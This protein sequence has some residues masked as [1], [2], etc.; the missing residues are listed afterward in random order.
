[1]LLFVLFLPVA[2]TLIHIS[3]I[4]I[5]IVLVFSGYDVF[6]VVFDDLPLYIY[7]DVRLQELT[8]RSRT[9]LDGHVNRPIYGYQIN[10]GYRGQIEDT[11]EV[12]YESPGINILT[13][14]HLN[15]IKT[16]EERL[17]NE[18][19]FQK[20]FCLLDHNNY[21]IKPQSLIRLFDGTYSHVDSVFN[22][23]NFSNINEV[24][25]KASV[26]NE[27][28]DYLQ[29]FLGKDSV[30][31]GT[32]SYTT[33]TRSFFFMGWPL[34]ILR[35]GKWG[36][37]DDLTDY[38]ADTF[39]PAIENIR[40]FYL[41]DSFDVYYLS[42]VLYEHDLLEQALVDIKLAIGSVLFI[43]VFMC[44]QT[45]T[46]V[47][48]FLGVLSIISSYL[49]TNLFY[50]YVFQFKYFGFFHVIAI[51]LILGI[52]ADDL[53]VFYDTWRLT[54]RTKYPSDA[55]RLS[56]CYRKAAKTTFV[57]SLTTT[58]AFLVSGLSPLLP[59][60][61][62][63]IFT[64]C[65]VAVNYLWVIIY[66]PSIIIIHHTKTKNLWQLFHEFLLSI[67]FAETF[68]KFAEENTSDTNSVSETNSSKELLASSS[69]VNGDLPNSARKYDQ[70]EVNVLPTVSQLSSPRSSTPRVDVKKSHSRDI[71][72]EVSVTLEEDS[73]KYYGFNSH[74]AP[75]TTLH[76]EKIQSDTAKE[77]YIRKKLAK[78]KKNFEERNRV[79][80]F[81]RNTFF[82]F[83]TNRTVKITIPLLFLGVSIFF[84]HRATM[85]QPDTH[86]VT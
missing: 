60:K 77:D 42:K 80:K 47:V 4:A 6:P 20:D 17:F 2:V 71:R 66:F 19:N 22:D 64:G 3:T 70:P 72:A 33:I 86:Q 79:V 12:I 44:F 10:T 78:P 63:G 65:L 30:V 21:C 85:I 52:G 67:W 18:I 69:H 37:R 24:L 9:F 13:P 11:V 45:G 74:V 32:G 41:I 49:L 23:M 39:K 15:L 40:D 28:K 58:M 76:W 7:N 43:F 55:H 62:F 1:M 34:Y 48:T 27:T 46:V 35:S 75:N 61:T 8:W 51:F 56:D 25:Y 59:V 83:M 38:L 29:L 57:T 84:I 36:R 54:G 14:Q 31:T 68:Q 81:L 26:Y 73:T 50:R 82:D 16:A 53:F 5:T